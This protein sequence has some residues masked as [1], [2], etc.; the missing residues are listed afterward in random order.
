MTA[1]QNEQSAAHAGASSTNTVLAHI[2]AGLHA[3]DDPRVPGT[4]R[5]IESLVAFATSVLSV[6]AMGTTAL[7]LDRPFLFPSLG[8][9]VFL[10]F[11][12]STASAASP[13]NTIAGHA[14]GIVAGLASLALFGL[15]DAPGVFEVGMSAERVGATALSLGLTS[16]AMTGFHLPHPPAGA[17]TLIV[18]LGLMKSGADVG[19]LMLA[20]GVVVLITAGVHAIFGTPYPR[21]RP[22]KESG[23]IHRKG[24]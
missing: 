5:I 19:V 20:I 4:G 9:T 14:I 24:A 11:H 23:S 1:H 2:R 10:L 18:S 15:L 8:A 22:L 6:S 7:L 3:Q 21:W 13:R 16:A 12:R 17:T